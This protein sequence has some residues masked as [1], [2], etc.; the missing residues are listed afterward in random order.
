VRK[1]NGL[2]EEQGRKL[3][4]V[5]DSLQTELSLSSTNGRREALADAS[6]SIQFD[7]PDAVVRAVR[8]VVGRVRSAVAKR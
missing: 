8:E 6:H 7:R 5:W 1:A 3:A 2:T 4:V